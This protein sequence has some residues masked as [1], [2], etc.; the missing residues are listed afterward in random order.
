MEFVL[1]R[2]LWKKIGLRLTVLCNITLSVCQISML[3][4]GYSIDFCVYKIFESIS[5]FFV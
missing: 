2:K 3:M 4:N 1:L 5:K